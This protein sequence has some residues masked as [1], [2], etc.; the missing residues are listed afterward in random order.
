MRMMS[1]K[2]IMPGWM[3]WVVSVG[4]AIAMVV[5][6]MFGSP[7]V[8]DVTFRIATLLMISVSW[9]LMAGAGLVSLG[10]SGFWGLG[11]YAAALCV[12]KLGFSFATSLIP[13]T[14]I[15]AL[16]GA[17]LAAITGR[18]R[19]IYFAICTL[20]MSE[21]LR[22]VAV[23]LPDVTGGSNGLYLDATKHP[24]A[25]M[26]T[27]VASL[28]AISAVLISWLL[29]RSRYQFALRA[30]RDNEAASQMLGVE[31][32]RYRIGIMALCGAMASFAG[33]INV[34]RGGY[35]DPGVAFELVTTINAQIAP[36]L[37]GIYTLP[38]PAIGAVLTVALGEVTRLTLGNIVGASLL[39]YGGLLIVI[40]LVLPNGVYGAFRGVRQLRR[41]SI[42]GAKQPRPEV[43]P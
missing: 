32:L 40:V 17:G 18:L 7:A 15:G 38:G 29:S 28:G 23:M 4:T 6:S 30:M 14:I 19:G 21:G 33:G 42:F 20:A 1:G 43:V 11:S 10:H 25:P 36:I 27:I 31:P 12:N 9:N 24:G 35:L 16:I 22:V 39:L 2:Q 26:V 3:W 34:W 41:P 37:G 8:S 5:A 13:A